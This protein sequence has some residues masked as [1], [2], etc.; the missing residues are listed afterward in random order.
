MLGILMRK[1]AKISKK[2]SIFLT[3]QSIFD[4]TQAQCD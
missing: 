1:N 3:W 2:I 4:G